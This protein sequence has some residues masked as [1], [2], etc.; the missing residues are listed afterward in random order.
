VLMRDH[1]VLPATHVYRMALQVSSQPSAVSRQ[2]D[3]KQFLTVWNSPTAASGRS[4]LSNRAV[5]SDLDDDTKLDGAFV[6]STDPDHEAEDEEDRAPPEPVADSEKV[7]Q[8]TVGKHTLLLR[9][10]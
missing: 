6:Y 7:M 10:A 9:F 3:V 4:C 5:A 8:G 2:R 1:T